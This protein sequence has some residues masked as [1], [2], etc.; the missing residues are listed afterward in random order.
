MPTFNLLPQRYVGWLAATAMVAGCTTVG[1]DFRTPDA[2]T[3]TRYTREAPPQ[4]V[5][6]GEAV[7]PEWWT[8]FG[9]PR[10][11]DLVKQALHDN[12][13]LAAA[14]ATLRQAQQLHAAQAGST[15]YPTVNA[16]LGASRNQ[17]NA[18]GRGEGGNQQTLYNLYNAGVAVNYNF[19]LFGGNRRALEALAA[20]ADYQAYQLAGARLALAGNIVTT[21]FAQA[22]LGEQIAATDAI[23][24]AQQDQLDIARKRF[25]LGATA[26]TEVLA[27][28]TQVE[29]TRASLPPLRNQLEQADHLLAVLTARAPGAADM[30]RF[31]LTDFTLPERLPVVVPSDLVRQ[32]PDIQ[33]STA[34][35]HAAT[36]QYGVAV[37]NLY[38]QIDLSASLGTQAL[39]TGALFGPG[40]MI[41]T[42]AGQLAQPLFNAGLKAGANA[43]EASLQAAGANYQQ[44]VLEALR[45]VADTLRQ[46]D[47]DAQAL[48]ARA[49]ADAS[50]QASLDLVRQQYHLGAAS[51]LQLLT[52]QQ[53]AR[54]TRIGLI[55]AQA[56]RL[57]DSA[58]LYQ[59]MGGGVLDTPKETV[60]ATPA[61]TSATVP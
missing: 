42:L 20:Q 1:P 51:Y 60:A 19:D 16:K 56:A 6:M 28:Q 44:T 37:S 57:A 54:Q 14:E 38:P 5:V 47:N 18:A 12:F 8:A 58:A 34:L 49:A 10:L 4:R 25:E 15:L 29:Q 24:Q 61:A 39:T 45:N 27:L 48:Q 50:A 33:A 52:A 11:D 13:T 9:S 17:A 3:V 32:R 36:A 43:A 35:L 23:L 59:A 53:Q 30:P 21:A 40:S 26:R 2:P 46:L 7:A 41:W 22:Q 31:A 55:A